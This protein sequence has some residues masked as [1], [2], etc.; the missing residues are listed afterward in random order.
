L[1]RVRDGSVAEK[2]HP[3]LVIEDE[4]KLA[5]YLRKGLSEIGY[6]VDLAT[7]GIASLL[8]TRHP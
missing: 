7:D 2:R 1:P 5:D 4:P 6:V 8:D 3:V